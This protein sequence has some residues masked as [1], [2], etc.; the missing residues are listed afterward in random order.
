MDCTTMGC[1]EPT[2]TPPT[3]AVT[4][5]RRGA[6]DMDGRCQGRTKSTAAAL[7]RGACD[8]YL[9]RHD[10]ARISLRDGQCFEECHG[11]QYKRDNQQRGQRL[12]AD[13]G[14]IPPAKA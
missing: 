1:A 4:V 8:G 10:R 5:D 2:G 13:V 9:L 14:Q 12:P 7:V 3:N 11:R 6:K